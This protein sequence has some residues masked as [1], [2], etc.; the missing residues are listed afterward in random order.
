MEV[1]TGIL[2]FR[3]GKPPQL[4]FVAKLVE[5]RR[6]VLMSEI[7]SVQD[8]AIPPLAP[9]VVSINLC[10]HLM[11]VVYNR[12]KRSKYFGLRGANSFSYSLQG[13]YANIKWNFYGVV[14]SPETDSIFTFIKTATGIW[15][16]NAV[17]FFT[18]AFIPLR[19]LN[20][21]LSVDKTSVVPMATLLL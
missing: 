2:Q 4:K 8:A 19:Y 9:A 13:F 11:N 10:R 6:R 1:Q 15:K 12:V 18:S 14:V 16:L 17:H 20:M 5:L 21:S 3:I 7:F